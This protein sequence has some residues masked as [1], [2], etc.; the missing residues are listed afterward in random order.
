MASTVEALPITVFPKIAAPCIA[1]QTQVSACVWGRAE[2]KFGLHREVF[3]LRRGSDGECLAES[4]KLPAG[5]CGCP[6]FGDDGSTLSAMGFVWS[7]R[8]SHFVCV[9]EKLLGI[10]RGADQPDGAAL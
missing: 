6:A 2:H 10:L 3:D 8:G 9:T 1:E 5:A 4:M 7:R